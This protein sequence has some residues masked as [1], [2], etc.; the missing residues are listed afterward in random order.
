[1]N[2]GDVVLV[3][4]PFFDTIAGSKVRPTLV[5]QNDVWNQKLDTTIVALITGSTKHA[6]EASNLLIDPS[7]PEGKSSG[8]HGLSV[9]KCTLLIT[10][11]QNKILHHIGH[12]SHTLMQQVNDCLK[13][14]LD[15]P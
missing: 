1:M 5:V 14:A 10:I 13:T 4:V 8:L 7:K 11:H 3:D 2:R 9:L 6:K 15:I 12:F